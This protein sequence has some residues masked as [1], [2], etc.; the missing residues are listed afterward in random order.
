MAINRHYRFHRHLYLAYHLT[1]VALGM[2]S[3]LI[4]ILSRVIDTSS[5]ARSLGIA[6]AVLLQYM[7]FAAF[8]HHRFIRYA[9]PQIDQLLR[10]LYHQKINY[11]RLY[12]KTSFNALI[13]FLI[14]V[15]ICSGIASFGTSHPA[16]F[17]AVALSGVLIL[18]GGYRFTRKKTEIAFL[19]QELALSG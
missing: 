6:T 16:M 4:L 1:V 9:E 5:V 13:F 11:P 15:F 18:L 3:A 2:I 19:K 17:T 12:L 7:M 10:E 8:V 14:T